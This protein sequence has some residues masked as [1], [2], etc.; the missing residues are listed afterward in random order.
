M[1]WVIDSCVLLDVAL[2]DEHY[3][4][5]SAQLLERLRQTDRLLICPVSLVEI[6]PFFDGDIRAVK[7]FSRLMGVDPHALWLDEDTRIAAAAW[8][9]QVKLK[10]REGIGRR[11]MADIL[12]GAFAVHRGGLVTRNPDH[13]ISI[14]PELKIQNPVYFRVER[15]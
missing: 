4:Q 15:K 3:G 9:R 6:A 1:T 13:F 5:A 10:R 2:N 14:F 7:E 12:I 11:P 8:T